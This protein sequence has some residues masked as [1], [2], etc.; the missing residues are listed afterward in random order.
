MPFIGDPY[1]AAF[2]PRRFVNIGIVRGLAQRNKGRKTSYLDISGPPAGFG[3]KLFRCP[4]ARKI[5][6][7]SGQ[8]IRR[9]PGGRHDARGFGQP[10]EDGAALIRTSRPPDRPS[11][12]CSSP[13][14]PP[15]LSGARR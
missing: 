6:P 9:F 2:S 13:P 1:P 7:R 5:P 15:A 4:L 11:R 14:A 12:T 8:S 10:I 3:V